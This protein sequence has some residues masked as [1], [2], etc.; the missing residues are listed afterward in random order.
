[1]GLQQTANGDHNWHKW[2]RCSANCT[3]HA[4]RTRG[5]I[6]FTI[7]LAVELAVEHAVELTIEST[8]EF[9]ENWAIFIGQSSPRNAN[10][11]T[12]TEQ[13]SPS[14]S[15]SNVHHPIAR[16][17][18]TLHCTVHC[19]VYCCS[20]YPR[21]Y[22][23][24][25]KP[26][27]FRLRRTTGE[28]LEIIRNHARPWETM[29]DHKEPCETMRN[30]LH[31]PRWWALLTLA[32]FLGKYWAIWQIKFADFATP[33]QWLNW[34]PTVWWTV[35]LPDTFDLSLSLGSSL[36]LTGR[37]QTWKSQLGTRSKRQCNKVL[38]WR[39]DLLN[40]DC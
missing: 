1:M 22:E 15:S 8:V 14:C 32:C 20:E 17:S 39:W 28:S 21:V 5:G 10:R 31:F 16:A 13:C 34:S 35:W 26:S 2:P 3:L 38:L 36:G 4:G 30:H 23:S 11:L 24:Q 7:E 12:F 25:S 18:F 40:K 19:T 33:K 9:T 27:T 6:E 37:A 29:Q